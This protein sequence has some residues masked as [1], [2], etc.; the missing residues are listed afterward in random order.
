MAFAWEGPDDGTTAEVEF[1]VNLHGGLP[2]AVEIHAAPPDTVAPA[3]NPLEDE[4][5]SADPE[6]PDGGTRVSDVLTFV[7]L[8]VL[9]LGGGGW[10]LLRRR[11]A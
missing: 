6:V 8:G 2:G 3:D 10:F 1:I 9:V 11:R 7:A 5:A 4:A